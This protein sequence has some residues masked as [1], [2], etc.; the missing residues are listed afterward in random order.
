[1]AKSVYKADLKELL[2][3]SLKAALKVSSCSNW[4]IDINSI[5]A[6]IKISGHIASTFFN[7][8]RW[9]GCPLQIFKEYLKNHTGEN[10]IPTVV[11]KE[12]SIIIQ[13]NYDIVE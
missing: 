12:N 10:L 5:S 6:T 2:N 7:T 13:V 1:M 11:E 3:S 9:D 8:N 4:T